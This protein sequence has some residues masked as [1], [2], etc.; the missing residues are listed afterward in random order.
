MKWEKLGR[1]KSMYVHKT[2]DKLTSSSMTQMVSK[3]SD[4]GVTCRDH[5]V[6]MI[7]LH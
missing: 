7:H 4:C 5:D 2:R 6:H 1:V 3:K